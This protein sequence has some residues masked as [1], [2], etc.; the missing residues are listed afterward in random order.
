MSFRLAITGA[1]A[2]LAAG[3]LAPDTADAAHSVQEEAVDVASTD[4]GDGL[5][6]LST[7]RAGNL[8]VL[9]GP[10]GVVLIDDQL[11]ATGSLIEG[12]VIEVS[13]GEAP[14][15]VVNT[16]WHFDHTGG[17]EHFAGLGATIAA[18]HNVR[19]RLDNAEDEWAS[20]AAVLPILTFGDDLSFHM[21]GQTVEA[22]HVPNAHTDGDAMVYFR[23]ADVLHM[24]DT[25]FSGFYPFIDLSS[26]GSV[27]GYIAAMER[28]LEIAGENTRI[29]PGHGP[30]ATP[31]DLQASIDM[32]RGAA[33]RVRALVD[34]GADLE[35]VRAA[36]PL[37]DLDADWSWGFISTDRMVQILYNDAAG[38]PFPFE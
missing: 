5:W 16:H 8:V 6:M 17:N 20:D 4:L 3:S 18:H 30:L 13:G 7:G 24:G 27:D 31:A 35:A 33:G 12:A 1:A 2:F 23:E 10:D 19:A 22:V 15:F 25:M 32:L 26:G 36:E 21:N 29:V 11:P 28:G 14:R 9:T 38:N 37:A 34:D